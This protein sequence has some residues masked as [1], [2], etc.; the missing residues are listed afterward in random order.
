MLE[1]DKT[2]WYRYDNF[3]YRYQISYRLT[4]LVK[5]SMKQKTVFRLVASWDSLHHSA[6]KKCHGISACLD[7]KKWGHE[8][9]CFM[10]SR[11]HFRKTRKYW[12]MWDAEDFLCLWQSIVHFDCV[13]WAVGTRLISL[14]ES[15]HVELWGQWPAERQRWSERWEGRNLRTHGWFPQRGQPLTALARLG[16]HH[17]SLATGTQPANRDEPTLTLFFIL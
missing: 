12:S 14:A 9:K 13:Q 8:N 7:V 16:S 3:R 2:I 1:T 15:G 11:C 10:S 17:S 6:L 4:S 5:I